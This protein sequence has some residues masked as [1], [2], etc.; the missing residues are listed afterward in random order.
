MKIRK[1]NRILQWF[2]LR[3]YVVIPM[4]EE[5]FAEMGIGLGLRWPRWRWKGQGTFVQARYTDGTSGPWEKLP[6]S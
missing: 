5:D 4:R 1:I 3:L 6:G 2:G